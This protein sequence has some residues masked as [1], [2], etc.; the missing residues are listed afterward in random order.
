MSAPACAHGPFDV[1]AFFRE[2][3]VKGVMT[4]KCRKCGQTLWEQKIELVA[5]VLTGDQGKAPCKECDEVVMCLRTTHFLAERIP[6]LACQKCGRI[7]GTA[8]KALS[9]RR[10]PGPKSLKPYNESQG[11]QESVAPPER[12]KAK[13]E[14]K[15]KTKPAPKGKSTKRARQ[16]DKKKIQGD[17]VDDLLG[18]SDSE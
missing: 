15:G 5:P 13:S 4:S 16:G 17:T 8:M 12:Q 2:D 6:I 11:T 10:R 3:P 14:D 18:T 1:E 9:E 7:G